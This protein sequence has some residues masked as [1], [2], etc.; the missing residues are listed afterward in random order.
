MKQHGTIYVV[1]VGLLILEV[2][3]E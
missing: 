2:E 3:N 1:S